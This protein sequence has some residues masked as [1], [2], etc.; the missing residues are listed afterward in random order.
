MLPDVTAYEEGKSN[1]DSIRYHIMAKSMHASGAIKPKEA[2]EFINAL[3]LQSV[4]SGVS[5]EN[6]IQNTLKLG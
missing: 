6:H 5:L 1:Y 3:K 2:Y 4:V